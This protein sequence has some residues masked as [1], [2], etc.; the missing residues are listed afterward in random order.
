MK[1]SILI[2]TILAEPVS[3]DNDRNTTDNRILNDLTVNNNII[4]KNNNKDTTRANARTKHTERMHPQN[5]PTTNIT[6]VDT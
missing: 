5:N 4:T 6:I 1:N 2:L 3:L